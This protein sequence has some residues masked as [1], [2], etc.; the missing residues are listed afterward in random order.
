MLKIIY[1]HI[2]IFITNKEKVLMTIAVLVSVS[3]HMAIASI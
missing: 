3:A 2:I 1:T